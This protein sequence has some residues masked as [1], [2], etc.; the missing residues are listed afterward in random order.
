VE[1]LAFLLLGLIAMIA[2]VPPIVRGKIEESPLDSTKNFKRS[3]LEMAA[4]VNPHEYGGAI[5]M[6]RRRVY[7]PSFLMSAGSDYE[8]PQMTPYASHAA[9]VKASRR[10]NRT[11]MILGLLTLVTG[12]IAIVSPNALTIVLFAICAILLLIYACLV[13]FMVKRSF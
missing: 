13:Y 7:L 4:S 9:G 1:I 2:I 12:I 11:Y 10:R 8:S 5:T 3:M 6:N